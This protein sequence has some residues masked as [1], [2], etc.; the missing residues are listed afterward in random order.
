[1][2]PEPILGTMTFGDTVDAATAGRCPP[3]TVEHP[4]GTSVIAAKEIDPA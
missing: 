1:M 4:S 2:N 3:T